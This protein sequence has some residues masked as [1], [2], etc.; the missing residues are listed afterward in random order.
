M[1]VDKSGLRDVAEALVLPAALDGAGSAGVQRSL[2]VAVHFMDAIP[3]TGCRSCTLASPRWQDELAGLVLSAAARELKLGERHGAA[4]SML[5]FEPRLRRGYVRIVAAADAHD[6]LAAFW[7]LGTYVLLKDGAESTLLWCK[8][9]EPAKRVARLAHFLRP[10]LL[11]AVLTNLLADKVRSVS[12]EPEL[13]ERGR[14]IVCFDCLPGHGVPNPIHLPDLYIAQKLFPGADEAALRTHLGFTP[15]HMRRYKLAFD[16]QLRPPDITSL[17]THTPVSAPS[18]MLRHFEAE[19]SASRPASHPWAPPPATVH[20]PASPPRPMPPPPPRHPPSSPPQPPPQA[21][22]T[23][24]ALP[25]PLKR[26]PTEQLL[27][28]A[29]LTAARFR[30]AGASPEVCAQYEAANKA[31]DEVDA[32]MRHVAQLEAQLRRTCPGATD[33]EIREMLD[34]LAAVDE[35]EGYEESDDDWGSSCGAAVVR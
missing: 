9:V 1:I 18:A 16:R 26:P 15:P 25:A 24:L 20:C 11:Q 22:A 21:R 5:R 35:T 12:A 31:D 4:A 27:R 34:G 30:R 7:R 10:D 32:W 17:P 8:L 2:A 29:P 19:P 6:R 14:A 28:E 33:A 23:P 3:S 13:D